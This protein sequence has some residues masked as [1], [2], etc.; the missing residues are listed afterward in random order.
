MKKMIILPITLLVVI[1]L[2]ACNNSVDAN[3]SN[4]DQIIINVKNNTNFEI[5]SLELSW[6]QNGNLKGTQGTMN[7]NDSEIGKGESFVFELIESDLNINEKALFEVAVLDD[8]DSINKITINNKVPFQ[9]AKNT[10]YNFEIRGD[11]KNNLTLTI[12]E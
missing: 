3:T 12:M 7:A 9:L 5:Y 2:T 10:E 8:K 11:T 4:K 6:Y 1:F